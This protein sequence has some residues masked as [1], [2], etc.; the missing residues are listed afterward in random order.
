MHIFA[1]CTLKNVRSR[2]ILYQYGWRTSV[3]RK[4]YSYNGNLK[5]NQH[6]LITSIFMVRI[7]LSSSYLRCS[8]KMCLQ[9]DICYLGNRT[10]SG[11]SQLTWLWT[12]LP[13][14]P[15]GFGYSDS[16]SVP[17]S[18]INKTQIQTGF[19]SVL[20]FYWRHF[21]GIFRPP[22]GTLGSR[23]SLK[24]NKEK[25]HSFKHKS[26]FFG[27]F[28]GFWPSWIRIRNTYSLAQLISYSIWIW[29]RSI[30][31]RIIYFILTTYLSQCRQHCKYKYLHELET[32]FPQ[33]KIKLI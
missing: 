4:G 12:V 19:P 2:K 27:S 32:S 22:V 28:G 3:Q 17:N 20:Q 9:F 7:N 21:D 10:M 16:R 29:T 26:S 6:R 31:A 24:P 14:E 25:Y 13:W 30:F 1:Q 8:Q 11:L 5:K 23:R 18:L 15:R 33:I